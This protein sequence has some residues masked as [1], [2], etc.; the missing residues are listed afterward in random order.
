MLCKIP[1]SF[2]Q[3]VQNLSSQFG[4]I[5]NEQW[6][7]AEGRVAVILGESYRI[8]TN[9]DA[10]ILLVLKE[11]GPSETNLEIISCA[12]ASGLLGVSWG[13]H[14]TYV[15]KVRDRL[16]KAGLEVKVIKEI[17]YYDSSTAR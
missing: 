16:Q 3:L 12:G 4:N 11:V 9:S 10:A 14:S 13:A 5:H 6:N 17:P 2:E 8:S 1:S 15:H 7:T